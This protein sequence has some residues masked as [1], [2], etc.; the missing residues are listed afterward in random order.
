[1][2]I[3]DKLLEAVSKQIEKIADQELRKWPPI[4]PTGLWYEP[5]QPEKKPE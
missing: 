2:K 3:S 5:K 1:M 4:C